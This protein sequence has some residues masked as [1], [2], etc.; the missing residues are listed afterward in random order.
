VFVD[1]YNFTVLQ[2]REMMRQAFED[3]EECFLLI[4]ETSDKGIGIG[5]E[6]GYAKAKNKPIIYVREKNAPH[7]TTV[8][9]T[10][11][12]QIIYSNLKELKDRLT[13]VLNNIWANRLDKY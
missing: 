2:E 11:D 8:C 6:V 10:S 9:G 1:K 4:A 3:I 13:D 5:V 7:S 12:Y